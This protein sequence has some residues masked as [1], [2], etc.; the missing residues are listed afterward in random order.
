[1]ILRLLRGHAAR[2]T[3]ALVAS[4]GAYR[5]KVA[6]FALKP[7]IRV[8][9]KPRLRQRLARR[10][11]LANAVVSIRQRLYSEERLK[12]PMKRVGKRG[13]GRFERVSWDQALD[14]IAARLKRPYQ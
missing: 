3:V 5:R 2:L 10:F 7:I 13:E 14:E 6:S 11:V 12:F 4:C 9:L 8:T 1:M